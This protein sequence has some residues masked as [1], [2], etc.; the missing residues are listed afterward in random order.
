MTRSHT[1]EQFI[2]A[3]LSLLTPVLNRLDVQVNPETLTFTGPS[4]V[5]VTA[6]VQFNVGGHDAEHCLKLGHVWLA[7]RTM[8][9]GEFPDGEGFGPLDTNLG[10]L[11]A[12]L[13]G[14][15]PEDLLGLS[16]TRSCV[17]LGQRLFPARPTTSGSNDRSVRLGGHWLPIRGMYGV[18]L[19]TLNQ[20][21]NTDSDWT[22]VTVGPHVLLRSAE[23]VILHGHVYS[24]EQVRALVDALS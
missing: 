13:D 3:A 19:G 15:N 18:T 9:A 17:R 4:G 16:I 23:E 6:E 1:D 5:T 8:Y 10:A 7:E 2:T 11:C 21:L 24:R 12:V 14:R 20:L 22:S